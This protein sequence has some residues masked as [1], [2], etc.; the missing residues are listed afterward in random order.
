[1]SISDFSTLLS[2]IWMIFF[3]V[4]AALYLFTMFCAWT[5]A[6]NKNIF[7]YG[8]WFLEVKSFPTEGGRQCCKWG[9]LLT[10]LQLGLMAIKFIYWRD[11]IL[12]L[13]G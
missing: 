5:V 7:L 12:F 8:L 10:V 1:M 4:V 9:A 11:I 2:V 13:Y 3:I 6:T